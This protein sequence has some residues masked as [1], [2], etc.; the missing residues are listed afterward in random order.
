MIRKHSHLKIAFY[1]QHLTESLDMDLTPLEYMLKA[2]PEEKELEQMRRAIGR[3][4][5][6]GGQQTTPIRHLSDGQRSRLVFAWLA[7]SKPHM[8]FLDEPTNAL[9]P[10]TY[11]K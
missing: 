6:T 7:F 3:F 11:E 9:D 4:G 1:H 8:L 10:G 5:L 2:F